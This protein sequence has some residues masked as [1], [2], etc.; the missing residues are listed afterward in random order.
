[1]LNNSQ[2]N[3]FRVTAKPLDCYTL[4]E[5]LNITFSFFPYKRGALF[6][7]EIANIN[8][9]TVNMQPVKL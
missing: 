5:L 1:M 4:S 8:F 9:K 6:L 7:S 3:T 2:R